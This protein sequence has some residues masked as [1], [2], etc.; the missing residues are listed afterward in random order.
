MEDRK[1]SGAMTMEDRNYRLRLAL[2]ELSQPFLGHWLSPL[3]QDSYLNNKLDNAGFDM[4]G[5]FLAA[6]FLQT[7]EILH[8]MRF[9]L[10]VKRG[11]VMKM[12]RAIARSKF[13]RL[14][15]LFQKLK[16]GRGM[17]MCFTGKNTSECAHSVVLNFRFP[18]SRCLDRIQGL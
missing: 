2:P 3:H 1:F 14:G 10:R 9:L 12:S 16:A 6:G 11:D 15:F 18:G 7:L 13:L 8:P 5:N 4:T 17:A